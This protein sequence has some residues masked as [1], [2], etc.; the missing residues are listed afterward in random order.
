MSKIYGEA[1][2]EVRALDNVSF[3][4]K[5]GE[6][7][8]VIGSS[9]SGKSTLLNMIG[10]LDRPTEGRVLVDGFDTSDLTDNEISAFRNKK[11]G[12]VFQFANLL[13]DLTVLENVLLPN[14]IQFDSTTNN[15]AK[16]ILEKVG[17]KDQLFKRANKIS[18]GQAQRAAIA[19]GL[20]NNPTIVLADEPTGNLDSVTAKNVVEI[21]KKMAK[22]MG[23]TF[24]VVTHERAQFGDVD[25]VITIKDGRAFEGEHSPELEVVA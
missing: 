19:R 1:E 4:V 5:K 2:T 13:A 6:F 16:E 11:L 20:V 21:M 24:I 17:L 10:L 12:F 23:Q 25:R 9:G 14:Q 18:G 15:R 22:D 3:S 7:V 8:L